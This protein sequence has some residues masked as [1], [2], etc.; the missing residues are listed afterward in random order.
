LDGTARVRPSIIMSA[1]VQTA[2][3]RP[4]GQ[5]WVWSRVDG[6]APLVAASLAVWQW[7]KVDGTVV[8][9]EAPAIF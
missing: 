4:V 1:A 5:A 7:V 2:T 6:G 9:D 3:R 8:V